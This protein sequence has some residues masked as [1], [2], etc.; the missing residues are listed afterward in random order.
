MD[1]VVGA[2]P[3]FERFGGAMVV[4]HDPPVRFEPDLNQVSGQGIA[5]SLDCVRVCDGERL[6]TTDRWGCLGRVH[7]V[8]GCS[9]SAAVGASGVITPHS[10]KSFAPLPGLSSFGFAFPSTSSQF[11]NS[12][13]GGS[14]LVKRV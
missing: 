11:T 13:T 10:S 14:T 6:I 2:A 5:V 12:M 7:G 1:H 8:L 3:R 4:L 9:N